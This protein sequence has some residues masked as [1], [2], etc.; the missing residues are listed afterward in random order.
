MYTL[1]LDTHGSLISV[2]LYNGKDIILSTKE[3]DFNHD[4]FLAPMIRDIMKES[5]VT[6]KD[7]KNIVVIN[8]PGSFTGLRIGLAEAKT[9]SYLLDIPIYLVSTL[10]SYLVS[11]NESDGIAIIED[12][13]G[14]FIKEKKNGEF[15]KEEYVSD[16]SE[17]QNMHIVKEELDIKKVIEYAFRSNSV[18][19]HLVRANYV[20]KIEAEK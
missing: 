17:Y 14:Y 2:A 10:D 15:L 19:P 6:F 5:S 20:K 9:I 13:K 12:N 3:S 8:G 1:F 18:N 11:D 7:I 4:A 16:I